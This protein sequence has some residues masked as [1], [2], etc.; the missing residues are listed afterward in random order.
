LQRS[1]ALFSNA[2]L[3]DSLLAV[4]G[5]LSLAHV[6]HPEAGCAVP[7]LAAEIARTSPSTQGVFEDGMLG[8]KDQIQ[9]LVQDEAM[10]WSIMAQLVGAVMIARGMQSM[11]ARSALL[12][13]V[14]QQVKQ[15]LN[16]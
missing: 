10:A 11:P 15:L 6:D 16:T 8:L 1:I 5:Y 4:E 7:A 12:A 13:G 2:S 9:T 14:M 3:E